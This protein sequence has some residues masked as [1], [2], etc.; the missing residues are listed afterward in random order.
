MNCGQYTV[1]SGSAIA[2]VHAPPPWY[3]ILHTNAQEGTGWGG[4]GRMGYKMCHDTRLECG[5]KRR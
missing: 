2:D 1:D 3:G 5:N 4:G